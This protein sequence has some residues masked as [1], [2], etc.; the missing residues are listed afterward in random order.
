MVNILNTISLDMESARSA[1]H[2][3]DFGEAYYI[4]ITKEHMAKLAEFADHSA[5]IEIALILA[6]LSDNRILLEWFDLPVH[7]IYISEAIEGESVSRFAE[8]VGAKY[9]KNIFYDNCTF[10]DV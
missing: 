8:S 5:E 1:N 7:P 2:K 3:L 10:I 4:P 6:V 9:K